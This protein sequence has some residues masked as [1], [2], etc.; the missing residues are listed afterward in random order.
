MTLGKHGGKAVECEVTQFME[1]KISLFKELWAYCHVIDREATS[2]L[3]SVM[4]C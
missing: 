4:H 2:I 3:G 1:K